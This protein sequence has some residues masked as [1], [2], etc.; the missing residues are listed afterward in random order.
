MA[1][2]CDTN[3]IS[4]LVRP[5]PNPGVIAWS[6]QISSISISVI[7]LEEIT[8]G[9][10]AKPNARI[11]AWWN[12]FL[13]SSCQIVPIT[14]EIAQC[15]GQLRGQLRTE[16]KPRSQADMLIAATAQVYQLTLVTRNIR[17]FES[18]SITLLNPFT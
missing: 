18:C 9:L 14:L 15:C 11:Q 2:L 8:Y 6:N 13:Q 10:A 16:G 3:I 4:E 17:D 7:T 1:F 5:Q 12:N